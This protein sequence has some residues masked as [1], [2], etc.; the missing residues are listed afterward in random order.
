MSFVGFEHTLAANDAW[1]LL[2][3]FIGRKIIRHLNSQLRYRSV[4]I[5]KKKK[6]A[7]LRFKCIF[8]VVE[9]FVP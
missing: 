9:L 5:P 6:A 1:N 7:Y 2:V 3:L 8:C 4:H